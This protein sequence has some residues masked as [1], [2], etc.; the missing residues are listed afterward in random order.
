[1]ATKLPCNVR[2]SEAAIFE[3]DNDAIFEDDNDLYLR[4]TMMVPR[5]RETRRLLR[6]GQGRY[7]MLRARDPT[8]IDK[9]KAF[10]DFQ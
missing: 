2:S 10:N 3:D 1:M 9:K 4:T 8:N 5:T 6:K 7:R